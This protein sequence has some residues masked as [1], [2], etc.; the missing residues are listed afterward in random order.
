MENW[1]IEP[2]V[3]Q[4]MQL[5]L[6][7]AHPQTKAGADLVLCVDSSTLAPGLEGERIEWCLYSPS[8]S[9]RVLKNAGLQL[10]SWLAAPAE[11]F[12]L[13]RWRLPKIKG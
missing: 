10:C 13:G 12:E 3:A 1:I 6:A 9:A 11:L 4:K 2:S 7:G 5:P 8:T